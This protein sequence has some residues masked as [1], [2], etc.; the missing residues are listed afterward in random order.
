[1]TK[2]WKSLRAGEEQAETLL[3]TN[4]DDGSNNGKSHVESTN[5]AHEFLQKKEEAS[6]G[7]LR[8]KSLKQ[9]LAENQAEASRL[10]NDLR[11]KK[12]QNQVNTRHR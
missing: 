2:H 9:R 7:R 12:M 10:R 1:M 6:T 5:T 11:I 8:L 4:E 3:N